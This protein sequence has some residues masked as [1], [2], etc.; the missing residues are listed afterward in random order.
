VKANRGS[1]PDMPVTLSRQSLDAVLFDL[2]G[3][4]TGTAAVHARAWKR[5]FDEFLET[6]AG[7][8]GKQIAP[9]DAGADYRLYVDG[10]PRYDGVATFLRA[11]GID[12]P[13][14]SPEDPADA[15]TV[16]GLGKRKDRYFREVL[17][18]DGVAVYDSSVALV[19]ALLDAGFRVAVVSASKNTHLVLRAA[20]IDTL[21]DVVVD[22]NVAEALA[23]AG[24]PDPATYRE[25]AR[26]VGVP[27]ARCAVAED[28]IAG[29]Q[30]GHAGG[31]GL[32]IGVNREA[33]SGAL[34]AEGAD[35]E[36][37]DLAR[38]TV[39]AAPEHS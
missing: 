38:V 9:F 23:L 36:V 1:H 34:L 33:D 31:F 26:R 37:R 20:G 16:Y 4:L 15:E 35:V 27:P 5:L 17:D 32:V 30:A 22:G 8:A 21:F 2:D 10:R 19:H 18:R 3:V 12:L 25:A 29:V 7:H 14:G 24:K 13:R 39:A 28:A 11:R 6:R